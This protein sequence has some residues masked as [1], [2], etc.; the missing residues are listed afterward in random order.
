M[1]IEVLELALMERFHWTP[2]QIHEIPEHQMKK[3][4]TV[5]SARQEGIEIAQRIKEMQGTTGKKRK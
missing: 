4:M 3:L 2:N 5:M 1:P